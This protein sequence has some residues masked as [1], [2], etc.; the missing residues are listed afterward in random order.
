MT[1]KIHMELDILGDHEDVFSSC[2]RK[3]KL[4]WG[5]GGAFTSYT[6]MLGPNVTPAKQRKS[7]HTTNNPATHLGFQFCF[8][9]RQNVPD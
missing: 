4:G 8:A 5:G 2:P 6:S 3:K 7:S 9:D 1:R